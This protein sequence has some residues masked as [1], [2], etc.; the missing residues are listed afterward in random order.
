[1]LLESPIF[2]GKNLQ[3]LTEKQT[4]IKSC[5]DFFLQLQAPDGNFPAVLEEQAASEHKLVHWCHGASG[6]IY[7]L[8][9]AYLLFRDEKYLDACLKCGDLVWKKGLLK[10]GPGICHGIA[11]NGYV[12]LILYRLTNDEKHL[13]RATCFSEF[14]TNET[15][16]RE[17][18]RPD[19]P[20]SL[21]EGLAGT[22]CFL[23]DMLDP[24]KAQ[25]PFMEVTF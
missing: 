16:L 4:L 7:L 2:A 10:K 12:F 8:A 25:F 6:S 17:A 11:G 13:Y 24:Q 20:F 23:I 19:S 21:F 22:V 1:M 15:F 18:R 5:V 3:E 14:L 9:K